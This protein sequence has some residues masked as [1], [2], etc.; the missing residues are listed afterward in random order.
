MWPFI[1][2]SEIDWSVTISGLA[3]L[4]ATA[5]MFWSIRWSIDERRRAA[6]REVANNRLEWIQE[7]RSLIADYLADARIAANDRQ[8]GA[9]FDKELA[10]RAFKT[11]NKILLLLPP[12]EHHFDEFRKSFWSFVD[13]PEKLS[14]QGI[15]AYSN[16]LIQMAHGVIFVEQI[17]AEKE[18]NGEAV[19]RN[20]HRFTG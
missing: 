14:S 5:S 7:F 19:F 2:A 15:S 20:V 10:Q 1:P 12:A 3:A 6:L 13:D 16:D 17:A 4:V 8:T 9:A 11:Y 18:L